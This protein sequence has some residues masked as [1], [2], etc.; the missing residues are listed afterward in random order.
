MTTSRRSLLAEAVF[1]DVFAADVPKATTDL[2]WAGQRPI[3]V[4]ALGEPSGA[5]AWKTIPSWF[6]VARND[7]VFPAAA[8]R[9]AA[10]RAGAHTVEAGASHVAMI[11]QPAATAELIKRAAR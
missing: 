4:R 6:L 8:Q 2:M 5:P 9:F 1:H 11:A 7:D 3:D 10:Q